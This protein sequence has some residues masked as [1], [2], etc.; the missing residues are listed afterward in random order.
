MKPPGAGSAEALAG[1]AAP[2]GRRLLL[3]GDCR[4]GPSRSQELMNQIQAIAFKPGTALACKLLI[5]I[6]K[7]GE[8]GAEGV[9]QSS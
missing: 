6:D 2:S 7:L 1:G 3:C 4:A 8:E 5:K 9:W